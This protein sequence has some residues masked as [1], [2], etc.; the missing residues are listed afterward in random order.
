MFMDNSLISG[1]HP[2]SAAP[3]KAAP[4]DHIH[5]NFATKIATMD[6]EFHIL[7]IAMMT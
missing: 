6:R 7:D 5:R 1:F 2:S 3:K 4:F